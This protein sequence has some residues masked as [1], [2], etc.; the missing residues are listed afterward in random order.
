MTSLHRIPL[1]CVS[2]AL[3]V[4]AAALAGDLTPPGSPAPT[5]RTQ[6]SAL[7][8]SITSSGS[9]VVTGN[10][11]AAADT[12]GITISADH[13]TIDLGGFSLIGGGGSTG[14]AITTT[15]SRSIAV[16]N[17]V[18]RDWAGD[19]IGLPS[20]SEIL[21]EGVRVINSGGYG[22]WLGDSSTV[23]NCVATDNVD[24]G[25]AVGQNSVVSHSVASE[26]GR[27]NPTDSGG[28]IMLEHNSV[29]EHSTANDN[30]GN[31]AL[32][33]PVVA[34]VGVYA[35]NGCVIRDVLAQGNLS[36]GIFV[37]D[38]GRVADC[39]ARGNG[40]AGISAY[41]AAVIT[42][43]V[44]MGN[45][46][47]AGITAVENSLISGNS[48]ADNRW[49][50]V[51][52]SSLIR[53]NICND[54][55]DEGIAGTD[56]SHIQNNTCHSNGVGISQDDGTVVINNYCAHNTPSIGNQYAT[57]GSWIGMGAAYLVYGPA[58]NS[59]NTLGNLQAYTP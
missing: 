11:T 2:I 43:C 41:H 40:T 35:Q 39:V 24:Y 15:S 3:L 5:Q 46:T 17:G 34:G 8:F 4:G 30:Q 21:V 45:S 55:T 53:D 22:I 42:G 47:S 48:C 1:T 59:T 10:L 27:T 57:T 7:P 18:I 44:C 6:I 13:V 26:N 32:G 20:G 33:P 38:D 58:M 50:I 36:S 14:D 51:A 25:I 56:Y 9:Y 23:R 52:A 19:G 12:D 49:G 37:M 16:L 54:N 29:L 28:G 31:T